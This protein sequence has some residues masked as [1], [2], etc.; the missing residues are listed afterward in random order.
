MYL[1]ACS[2]Y[3]LQVVQVKA[4]P[5]VH[6]AP[7]AEEKQLFLLVPVAQ[8]QAAAARTDERTGPRRCE[9]ALLA[10]LCIGVHSQMGESQGCIIH[11]GRP[12]Y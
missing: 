12:V 11:W 5:S 7:T 6:A 9:E 10:N 1:A 2:S 4:Q 8:G 3:I